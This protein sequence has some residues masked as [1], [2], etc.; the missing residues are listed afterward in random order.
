MT[1]FDGL[2]RPASRNGTLRRIL[3]NAGWLLAGKG[4]GAVLSLVYLGIATRS[5]GAEGFG[6]LALIL[7]TAQ[8]LVAL[9]GFQ[10]WQLVVRYGMPHL[11]AGRH[12]KLRDL[13]RFSILLDYG[14][15]V[16]GCLLAF[17]AVRGLGGYF[18]WSD[19]LQDQALVFAAVML[20]TVRLT[21][22]GVL[23]LYDRFRT[24]ALADSIVPSVRLIGA[25][26]VLLSGPTITGFLIA[27]AAAE[28]VTAAATW[29][30]AAR[31][32][33]GAMRLGRP[34]KL[35]SLFADN[36][37]LGR[38]ALVTNANFTLG[39][40]A[41]QFSTVIVG[42]FAGATSAGYY[43]LAFQL[44]QSLAKVADLFA[45]AVFAELTRVHFGDS[46]ERLAKLFRASVR[47]TML[48]AAVVVALILLL[49]KPALLLVA[50]PEFAGAYPLLLLLGTAAALDLGGVTF[51]PALLATG[52]AG[53]LLKLR[54][55][56][57]ALLVVLL[58]AL[59]PPL[60]AKGAAIATLSASLAGLLLLGWG[61]WRAIHHPVSRPAA[62]E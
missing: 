6:Q 36:P 56:V 16:A 24:A 49:G 55:T 53:L 51:E 8:A 27:W 1:L 59:L 54:I 28:V 42:L 7:G 43:R 37:G 2:K 14:A 10:T 61:A 31:T 44:G 41:K 52:R 11:Q 32:A 29:W 45:R 26:L 34:P 40:V 25:L 48:A 38:F 46:S 60:G 21:A 5:L 4:F 20:L 19:A 62:P 39:A 33:K 18:G 9:V 23:R 47:F 12:E 13:L 58:V 3:E 35:S 57:T 15:A 50:G 22:T 17:I 30:I